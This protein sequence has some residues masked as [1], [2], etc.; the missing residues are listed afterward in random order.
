MYVYVNICIAY[1]ISIIYMYLHMT[2]QKHYFLSR[3]KELFF[4][5]GLGNSVILSTML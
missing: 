2:Y 5:E 4:P 1:I 3:S